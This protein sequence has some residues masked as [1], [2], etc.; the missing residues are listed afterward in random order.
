MPTCRTTH[1]C[2]GFAHPLKTP[3]CSRH[4]SS[5]PAVKLQAEVGLFTIS[6]GGKCGEEYVQC[7]GMHIDC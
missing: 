3:S 5:P 7:A 1:P 6:A 4:H 2:Q